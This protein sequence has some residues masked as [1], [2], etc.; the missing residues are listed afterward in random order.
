[1]EKGLAECEV[2]EI[3]RVSGNKLGNIAHF[4]EMKMEL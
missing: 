4:Y 1:V 2:S 3:E